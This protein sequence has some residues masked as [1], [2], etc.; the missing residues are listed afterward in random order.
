MGLRNTLV[1]V[2]VEQLTPFVQ[3]HY[4]TLGDPRN[5]VFSI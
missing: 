5:G 2:V 1:S 3:H 4:H